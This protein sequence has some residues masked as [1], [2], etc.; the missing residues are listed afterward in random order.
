MIKSD[1]LAPGARRQHVADLD[2]VPRHDHSVD[3]QFDQLP[4]LVEGRPLQACR[5]P[6][7]ERLQRRR[8]PEHLVEPLRLA[9]QPR[10]LLGQGRPPRLQ[11]ATSAA[12]L[13]QRDDAAQVRLGQP[14]E[15]AG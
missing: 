2:L 8:Q 9:G 11:V 13:R 5:D 4:P 3:Q 1:V 15:L 6:L 14:V 7:A 10:L 12:V